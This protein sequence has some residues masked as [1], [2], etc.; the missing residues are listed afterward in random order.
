[1]SKL[2]LSYV[3]PL[4]WTA[5]R[6]TEE[7]ASYLRY[8]GELVAEVVVVD[9]SPQPLFAAQH[10]ALASVSRH[11]SPD[12]SLRF[13]MGKADGVTTG[14]R[15]AAHERIIIADD[16]VRYGHASVEAVANLLER[17]E[18]VRPQNY[19]QPLPWH[20]AWD[21]ARSLL[22]RV[23]SG[24]PAHPAADFPGTL[25][26]R[27]SFFIDMGGYDG[28][29]LFENLELIR[30]VEAA[31]GHTTSPLGLYVS[32]LPPS[33]AHFLSQRVR[34][35]YDDLAL[36]LR[37]GVFLLVLPSLIAAVRKGRGRT[38]LGAL[39]SL[40]LVAE[41]GRRRAGGTAVFPATSSLLAPLW[42]LERAFCMW[43]AVLARLRG[44]V[45]YGDVRIARSATPMRQLR[46]R[47]V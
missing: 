32:R 29:N 46:R 2:P 25:G 8:L 36:P 4:R 5:P 35:A 34:Q 43:L 15:L 11:V 9:G 44:G 33:T 7:L 6:D 3:L 31:G 13:A 18:L 14:I 30:T 12:P 20:A 27:R 45:R 24:D 17:F 40:S 22:N 39:T 26:V 38:A 1:V 16:D 10:R 41:A 21:T 37:S 19:F 42:V 47:F 28:D 23:F